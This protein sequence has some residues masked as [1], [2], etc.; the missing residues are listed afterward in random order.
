METLWERTQVPELHERWDLRFTRIRYLPR[1]DPEEPQRFLYAT[2]IGFGKEIEG[3]GETVGETGGEG[4][5]R[6][7]SLRFWSDDR[8][9]L[10]R[11]GSGYWSYEPAE[12]GLRF[13]TGYDYEVRFGALGRLVDRAVF[14]PL[15]GW[16]TAWSFDRLRLWIERR[17]EPALSLRMAVV[18]ALARWTTAFVWIY[19]GLV[20]KLIVN[21]PVESEALI[22]SGFGVHTAERL[23]QVAGWAELLFGVLVLAA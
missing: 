10:I 13:I 8:R 6:S 12:D 2:R 1:P 14:R 16:A 22:A 9:S 17:I 18:H 20:P 15:M 5:A 19:H 23:V 21:D 4:G 7:S 3:R 11:S